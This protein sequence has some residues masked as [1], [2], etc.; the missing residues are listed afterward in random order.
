MK[1]QRRIEKIFE[2]VRAVAERVALNCRVVV[3]DIGTDHGFLAEKLSEAEF[4]ERVIASDISAKSLNKLERLIKLHS[5]KNIDTLLCDGLSG[6]DRAD[7]AVIAGLGGMQ[8]SEMLRSQNHS[9]NGVKCRYFVLQPVQNVPELRQFLNDCKFDVFMDF[10]VFDVGQYYHILAV[11]V[12]NSTR[13]TLDTKTKYLGKNIPNSADFKGFVSDV[14][15]R[16][17]F[18]NN[19]PKDKIAG[20]LELSE[21]LSLKNVVDKLKNM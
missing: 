13:E 15:N 1:T 9:K 10:V 16:L 2:T 20:D 14:S 6:L 7:I 5:L 12:L 17:E 21:K 11:D 18:L 3:A 8:I 4:V 19:L